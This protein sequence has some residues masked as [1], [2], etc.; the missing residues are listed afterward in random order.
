MHNLNGM[1]KTRHGK[2]RNYEK[3][4]L[5]FLTKQKDDVATWQIIRTTNIPRS[6]CYD[7]LGKLRYFGYIEWIGEPQDWI[8]MIVITSKGKDHLNNL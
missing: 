5:Q 4:I 2:Y 6:S 3:R 1:K 7:V 8:S